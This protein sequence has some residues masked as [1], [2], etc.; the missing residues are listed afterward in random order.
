M[1]KERFQ[2]LLPSPELQGPI[3][4]DFHACIDFANSSACL[5]ATC[6]G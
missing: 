6:W 5:S 3:L 2:I 4:R 1:K